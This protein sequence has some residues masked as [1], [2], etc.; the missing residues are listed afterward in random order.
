MAEVSPSSQASQSH[1]HRRGNPVSPSHWLIKA[2]AKDVS[3]SNSDP[4]QDQ[5]Q[6]WPLVAGASADWPRVQSPALATN[7]NSQEHDRDDHAATAVR[8]RRFH[9][10][11]AN[12]VIR[13]GL[14][15]LIPG[16]RS[17]QTQAGLG[18]RV[19][20]GAAEYSRCSSNG[21]PA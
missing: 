9:L 3:G 2:G 5:A 6:W 11:E 18:Q 4:R 15:H 17:N 16:E 12:G 1:K 19:S 7:E 13:P 21:L 14:R 10:H 8:N 20:A